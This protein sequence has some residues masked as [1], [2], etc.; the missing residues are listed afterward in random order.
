MH[1]QWPLNFLPGTWGGGDPGR[2]L[3]DRGRGG[4]AFYPA[5]SPP[6]PTSHPDAAAF[7]LPFLCLRPFSCLFYLF[8]FPV[9]SAHPQILFFT[10]VLCQA[11]NITGTLTRTSN[12]RSPIPQARH[13]DHS[14]S[15]L[16]A[17]DLRPGEVLPMVL[18]GSWALKGIHTE[19]TGT[20]SWWTR[21]LPGQ[22]RRGSWPLPTSC[23]KKQVIW[24]IKGA[25]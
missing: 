4:L 24:Y 10:T 7:L 14:V 20:G 13:P 22:T 25:F 17:P 9:L 8:I 3:W 16:H 18:G 19:G 5:L 15:P 2:V 6:P 1:M 21:L 11:H 23:P 12:P